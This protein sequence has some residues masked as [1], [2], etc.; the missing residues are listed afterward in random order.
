MEKR[1]NIL[2]LTI[3]QLESRIKEPDCSNSVKQA[4]N[5]AISTIKL[6]I[7]AYNAEIELARLQGKNEQL[8][9]MIKESK[10]KT[11]KQQEQ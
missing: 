3:K 11:F 10:L 4:L 7:P 5:F 2:D 8:K 6:A 1:I 9:E